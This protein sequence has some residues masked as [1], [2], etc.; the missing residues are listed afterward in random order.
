MGSTGTSAFR[1]DVM[2]REVSEWSD[3]EMSGLS[4]GVDSGVGSV[5][6]NISTVYVSVIAMNGT[7]EPSD[8]GS[9]KRETI[10]GTS[11]EDDV[12]A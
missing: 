8:D 1:G 5:A 9:G 10:G 7:E 12:I 3:N 6:A 11:S 2:G 4:D